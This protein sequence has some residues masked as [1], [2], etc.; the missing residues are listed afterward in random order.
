[1]KEQGKTQMTDLPLFKDTAMTPAERKKLFGA[2]V[3]NKGLHAAAPG[4]DPQGETCGSC[5]HLFRNVMAKTY[6]KCELTKRGWTGGAG[7]DVKHKDPACS[8]WQAE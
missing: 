4:S 8:K 3:S 2:K 6:F 5:A 1:M 7:T